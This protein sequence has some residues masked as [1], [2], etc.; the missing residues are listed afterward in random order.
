[1]IC[2]NSGSLSWM[3]NPA[4]LLLPAFRR[5]TQRTPPPLADA[6]RDEATD[7]PSAANPTPQPLDEETGGNDSADADRDKAAADDRPT[8]NLTPKTPDEESGDDAPADD[9]GSTTTPPVCKIGEDTFSTLDEAIIA[10]MPGDQIDLLTDIEQDTGLTF[11]GKTLTI[12]GG[13][14]YTLTLKGIGIYASGSNITFENLTLHIYAHIP[15][16]MAA[17]PT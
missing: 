5:R 8:V 4:R 10:A 1:M 16:R 17:R 13:D 15:I 12:S 9:T 3:Q 11:T 6:D 14:R 2:R 7:G